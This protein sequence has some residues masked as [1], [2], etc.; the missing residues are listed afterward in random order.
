MSDIEDLI[1]RF[2]QQEE[3][4]Y[5]APARSALERMG[6]EAVP[7]LIAAMSGK[8]G[9]FQ[10]RIPMSLATI[11][12]DAIDASIKTLVADA[13]AACVR[14]RSADGELR[15]EALR[16]L[17]LRLQDKRDA[18]LFMEALQDPVA[19]VRRYAASGLAE[20]CAGSAD[21][22]L[23]ASA[24]HRLIA[25]LGD[26]D[27]TVRRYAANA[28]GEVSAKLDD[29]DLKTSASEALLVLL[30]DNDKNV[31]A[32]AAAAL[33]KTGMGGPE[34]IQALIHSLSSQGRDQRL[35][36]AQ[37]LGVILAKSAETDPLRQTAVSRL[38][39]RLRDP[40]FGVTSVAADALGM[41][42][43]TAAVDPLIGILNDDDWSVRHAAVRAL[44]RIGAARALAAIRAHEHDSS[45]VV[46]DA[47][48][49]ALSK[50]A[51]G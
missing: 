11:A 44:G 32:D 30:E 18:S 7:A 20:F 3:Y 28:L 6:A 15:A 41:L 50:I 14:D 17:G 37:S 1:S 29:A 9:R 49:E 5:W 4:D 31:A 12:L 16:N 24:A 47:V 8:A 13:F 36:A 48:A 34:V 42:R 39:E 22:S 26:M 25:A 10:H 23:Q 35:H 46:R 27:G 21:G 19:Q 40:D 2:V 45:G 38:I 43:S 33:K 51:D